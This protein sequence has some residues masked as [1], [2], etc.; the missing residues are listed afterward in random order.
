MTI[1]HC[2]C[3]VHTKD[4]R[5][6]RR[7]WLPGCLHRRSAGRFGH[8]HTRFTL[9]FGF[10]KTLQTLYDLLLPE[11]DRPGPAYARVHRRLP[12]RECALERDRQECAIRRLL[13]VSV[14]SADP[15][16]VVY[17]DQKHAVGQSAPPPSPARRAHVPVWESTLHLDLVQ[18]GRADG[19]G[20]PHY[21]LG[22][23][24]SPGHS[25][26]VQLGNYGASLPRGETVPMQ[27]LMSA[28]AVF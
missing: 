23:W 8:Q 7:P 22:D 11:H 10:S 25:P 15:S 18:Q 5:T 2:S 21:I 14:L 26:Q 19:R 12:Q 13:E 16:R 24:S 28:T 20:G 17:D 9:S 3:V 1:F 27:N 6:S 4:S